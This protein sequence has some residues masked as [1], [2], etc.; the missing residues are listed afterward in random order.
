MV[1]VQFNVAACEYVADRVNKAMAQAKVWRLE[2][3]FWS[4]VGEFEQVVFMA[5][6]C[7]EWLVLK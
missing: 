5:N 2:S 6:Q 3:S 7:V 4:D 1:P